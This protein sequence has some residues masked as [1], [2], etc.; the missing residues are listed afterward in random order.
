MTSFHKLK[1]CETLNSKMTLFHE[2]KPFNM[3]SF[4]K[5]K[6]CET[7]NFKMTLFNAEFDPAHQSLFWEEP[8]RTE[9]A[10]RAKQFQSSRRN[11]VPQSSASHRRQRPANKQGRTL[12]RSEPSNFR[13]QSGT[14]SR[15]VQH[16]SGERALR[17]SKEEPW[18][19]KS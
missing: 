13:V 16:L 18:L 2:L 10:L 15:R 17:P 14:T 3:T 12:A 7:L 9:S 1:P 6:Y 8:Q 5:L 11:Y 19:A 4:H